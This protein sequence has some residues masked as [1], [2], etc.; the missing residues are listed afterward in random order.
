MYKVASRWYIFIWVAP[1]QGPLSRPFP[2][3]VDMI[4]RT[5]T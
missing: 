4:A 1:M 2:K 5:H 3:E